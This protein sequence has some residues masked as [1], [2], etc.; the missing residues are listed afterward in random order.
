VA[1]RA[2]IT[3]DVVE[4]GDDITLHFDGGRFPPIWFNKRQRPTAH[5]K[6][7]RVLDEIQ[8]VEEIPEERA[9]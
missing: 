3:F 2:R 5:S 4:R 1:R 6:L 8:V 7:R 9:S